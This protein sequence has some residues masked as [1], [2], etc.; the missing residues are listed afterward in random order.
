[1]TKSRNIA[2]PRRTWTDAEVQAMLRDYPHRPTWQ[3]AQEL[4]RPERHLYNK[5]KNMGL[6]KTPEYLSSEL[7]GRLR[8][9]SQVGAPWRFKPGHKTWNKGK[10]GSS[11]TH[12]NTAKNHFGP[13]N[14]PHTWVPVGSTRITHD[15]YL[16]RK[17]SDT[18]YPP[19]DWV[20]VQRLV[21]EAAHGP[22]PP[23]HRI[24][25]K[26]G[27]PITDEALIVP[28]ALECIT[29]AEAM[30]RNSRHNL[31]KP[32]SDLIQL[33]GALNRRINRLQRQA[34]QGDEQTP[35]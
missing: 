20:S 3:L 17:V 33:R 24:A 34:E 11:G 6:R 22:I 7:G 16:Q 10:P 19:R 26:G 35:T 25:F 12:P 31:P 14:R 1:M 5:A 18:G 30:R 28:E 23:G 29:P 13:G 2:P 32:L 9:D 8:S 15:G 4:G 21:W 27:K